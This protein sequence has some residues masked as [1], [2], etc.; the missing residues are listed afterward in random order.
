MMEMMM[1]MMKKWK[2]I[3]THIQA[4]LPLT[5]D[6]IELFF[7]AFSPWNFLINRFTWLTGLLLTRQAEPNLFHV[8]WFHFVF[9]FLLAVLNI[10]KFQ[11]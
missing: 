6:D 5:S 10:L 2:F 7:L 3:S 4:C 11:S 9:L 1:T 8:I